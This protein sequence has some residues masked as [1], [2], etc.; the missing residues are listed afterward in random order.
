MK[1]I[2]F[3]T[4]AIFVDYYRIWNVFKTKKGIA[5]HLGVSESQIEKYMK[6][7]GVSTDTKDEYFRQKL[8]NGTSCGRNAA[9]PSSASTVDGK[10]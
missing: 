6:E 5:N 1:I 4:I 3:F 10:I 9:A 2:N 8:S 7:V